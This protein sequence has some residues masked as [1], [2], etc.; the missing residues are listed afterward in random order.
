LEKIVRQAAQTVGFAVVN[1]VHMLCPEVIILGGGLVEAIQEIYLDEV[2]RTAKRNILPCYSGMFEIRMA[3]LGDDAGAMGAA[4]WGRQ[5]A[6]TT[7]SS[8]A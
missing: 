7:T 3:K 2:E 4:I 5:C 1:L 8:D 6:P